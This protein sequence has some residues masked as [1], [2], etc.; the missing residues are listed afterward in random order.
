MQSRTFVVAIGGLAF[1]VLACEESVTA[2]GVCPDFCPSGEIRL[3][4]TVLGGVVEEDTSFAGYV[5]AAQALSMQVVGGD[6]GMAARSVMWYPPFDDSAAVDSVTSGPVVALDSFRLD[7][8][9]VDRTAMS[10]LAVTVHRLP[11]T[12]DRE[13]DFSSLDPFFEDSTIVGTVVIPDSVFA[14]TVS[15]IIPADAFP[16][17]E[18]DSQ[19]VALGLSIRGSVPAFATFQ[20]REANLGAV[21]HRFVTVEAS[22]GD[23]VAGSDFEST[24]FDTFVHTDLPTPVEGS[25]VVG[26]TPSSRT[27]VRVVLPPSIMDSSDIVRAHLL[28]IPIEPAVGAPGDTLELLAEALGAVFGPKSPILSLADSALVKTAVGVGTLDTIAVDISAIMAFW[29]SDP[30][31]VRTL[32]VRAGVEAA[33]MAEVRLGSTRSLGFQPLIRVTYVPPFSFAQ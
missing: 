12:V 33:S 15:A 7:L 6:P 8:V 1:G 14:D 18:E 17:F 13:S 26:G 32:V 4:D 23:T 11:P 19:Q 30:E 2:P 5:E 29:Q 24:E 25:L 21:L 22:P 16:T 10:G 9:L 20:T 27:F 28:L 3:V 31:Q